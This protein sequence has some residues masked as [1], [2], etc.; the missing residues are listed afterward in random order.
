[1]SSGVFLLAKS[2]K[3]GNPTHTNTVLG[4]QSSVSDYRYSLFN[5]YNPVRAALLICGG[6]K[7]LDS[8]LDFL[9]SR[10]LT[11]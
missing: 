1:M 8:M 11:P 7:N 10:R 5:S 4:V 6:V 9:Q 2:A 3:M